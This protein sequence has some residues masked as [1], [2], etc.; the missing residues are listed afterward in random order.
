MDGKKREVINKTDLFLNKGFGVSDTCEQPVVSRFGEGAFADLFFGDEEIAALRLRGV[1]R[2]IGEERLQA[3]LDVGCD[4]DDEGG[5]DVGVEAGVENLEGTMRWVGAARSFDL[6]E[7]ADETGFVA[8]RGGG[9]VV[10]VAALPVR[11]DDDAGTQAAEDCGDLESI[12]VGVLDVAVGEIERFAVGDVE[13]ARCGRGFG[14]TI[15]RCTACAG[16]ALRQVRGCRCASR[17]RAWRGVCRR[18]SV[19]RR[20]GVRRWRGCRDGR[21]A[22][23]GVG[24][25]SRAQRTKLSILRAVP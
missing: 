7:A 17:G 9:V 21:L 19:R 5:A 4:V 8:K 13:D 23:L 1:L 16:L 2:A 18:R 20:R 14:C 11:E 25:E 6:G 24:S 12:F 22:P 15:G 10:R 3:L